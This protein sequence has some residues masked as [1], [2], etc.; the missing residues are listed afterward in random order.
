MLLKTGKT[1]EYFLLSGQTPLDLCPDPNLCKT[2]T[3]CRKEGASLGGEG[4]P[5][6]EPC[7]LTAATASTSGV[8]AA[9]PAPAD[10]AA[11]L[12]S[13]TQPAS[14]DPTADECLVCSDAKR[15]TLFRPCGHIC[16][17]SVCAARVMINF[18]HTLLNF[19]VTGLCQRLRPRY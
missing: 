3:T 7:S 18:F 8:T 12:T 1:K 19:S 14:S 2:L 10:S 16:C 5:D 6:S 9:S 11:A 15:D 17:C 4:T 13:P